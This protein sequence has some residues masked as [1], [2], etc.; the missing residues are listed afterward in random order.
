MFTKAMKTSSSVSLVLLF[1]S[2]CI[3]SVGALKLSFDDLVCDPTLPAYAATEDLQMK[4]GDEEFSNNDRCSFGEE[5]T[6]G[7]TI[8]YS[9]L[10][11]F[12]SD[13]QGYASTTIRILGIER[14][15]LENAPVDLCGDWV[16]AFNT[17][18]SQVSCPHVNDYYNFNVSYTLPTDIE[19]M[20]PWFA[21]D[22]SGLANLQVRSGLSSDS[23]VLADCTLYWYLHPDKNG[24]GGGGGGGGDD[25]DPSS[26]SQT[27]STFGKAK[28]FV[29]DRWAEMPSAG[30]IG[31]LVAGIVLL[32]LGCVLFACSG[33][34]CCRNLKRSKQRKKQRAPQHSQNI[35]PRIHYRDS[36]IA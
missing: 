14:S 24:S 34:F 31:I 26:Q 36:D 20:V 10:H 3:G 28:K 29:S 8:H 19:D 11:Q 30:R 27:T 22:A 1:A 12:T 16:Q 9:Q 6:I 35:S 13:G 23:F 4:C 2:V 21:K 7:G 5:L 18:G 25:S 17:S 33:V 32:I 15:L